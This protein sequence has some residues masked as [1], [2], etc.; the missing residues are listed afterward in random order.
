MGKLDGFGL[1]SAEG[2]CVEGR[3]V[4]ALGFALGLAEGLSAAGSAVFENP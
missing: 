4:G 2:L 1:G 3:T